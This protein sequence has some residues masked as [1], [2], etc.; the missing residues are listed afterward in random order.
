MKKYKKA[1]CDLCR[2]DADDDDVNDLIVF[3]FWMQLIKRG[4]SLFH[5]FFYNISGKTQM[6][7]KK[8]K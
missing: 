4:N 2:C 5:R 8:N 7:K 3:E 1:R 6:N